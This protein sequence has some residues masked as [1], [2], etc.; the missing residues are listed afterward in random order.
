M[1][2][3]EKIEIMQA[4]ANG[5]KIEFKDPLTGWRKVKNPM[6][7]W[8][9][10]EYRVKETFDFTYP[11]TVYRADS[12][13]VAEIEACYDKNIELGLL[14]ATRKQAEE[15]HV[16]MVESNRLE[17]LIYQFQDKITREDK[18][19]ILIDDENKYT[20]ID[21]QIYYP[22]VGELRCNKHT[23][24]KICKLLNNKTVTL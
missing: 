9:K 12:Y 3:K 6:W 20:Y 16:R 17:Q 22:L 11:P 21:R 1:K 23:A 19:A 15:S 2:T 4:Y 24:E 5:E 13:G 18:Y 7:N 14:R 10:Y 8:A